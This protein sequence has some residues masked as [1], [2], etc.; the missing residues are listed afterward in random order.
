MQDEA[1][2]I[3][4]LEEKCVRWQFVRELHS[5][6]EFEKKNYL[7]NL[8]LKFERLIAYIPVTVILPVENIFN[9]A[10][11]SLILYVTPGCNSGS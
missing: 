10:F 6:L 1:Y 4:K 7:V 9:V 8:I 11:G 5:W 3:H 2:E